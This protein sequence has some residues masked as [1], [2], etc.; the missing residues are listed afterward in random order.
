[1][2]QIYVLASAAFCLSV[3]KTSSQGIYQ[4]WGTTLSGGNENQGTIY[5]TRMDGGGHKPRPALPIAT[6]GGE[7]FG[8][9][10]LVYNN[11]IYTVAGGGI[12]ESGIIM[13]YDPSNDT[14]E[15]LVDM[16]TIGAEMSRTNLVLYNNKMYGVS[17]DQ[18]T[19]SDGFIFEFD[20]A[21]NGLIRKY[22]FSGTDYDAPHGGL[23]LWG[24]ELWGC[25]TAGTIATA[26][27]IYSYDLGSGVFTER[28]NFGTFLGTNPD[29]I[30][31][32][33]N[34]KIYGITKGGG[35][36][37]LGVLFEYNPGTDAYAV[38]H[39][40]SGG[41][42][43]SV[44]EGELTLYNNK[45]Y[46]QT[47]DEGA[48]DYG[49][50]FEFDPAIN[51]F[52]TKQQ[53]TA[54]N[55]GN[56]SDGFTLYNTK[57]Y[58]INPTGGTNNDGTVIEYDP[59]G[60]TVTKKADCTPEKGIR[61]NYQMTLYNGKMYGLADG[62]SPNGSGLAGVFFEYNP[63]PNSMMAKITFRQ[64]EGISPLGSVAYYNGKAF[65]LTS[66]GG[67][68]GEGVIWE[69]DL[70]TYTYTVRHHFDGSPD[71]NQGMTLYNG[72]LYGCTRLGGTFDDGVLYSFNPTNYTY[73][74][75]HS[76]NGPVDGGSPFGNPVVYN[77]KL[78]GTSPYSI[79]W[80]TIWEYALGSNT[81]T[82][83]VQ[84]DEIAHGKYPIAGLT[85]LNG[86]LW[87][88]CHNGGVND[89]GTI[90]EY[91]PAINGIIKRYDF[92]PTAA[93]GFNPE[94]GLTAV[95]NKLYG[96]TTFGQQ[97]YEFDPASGIYTVKADLLDVGGYFCKSKLA[98][99]DKTG[100]FYGT[101][102]FAGAL[103][104]G[105]LFE[106]DL[107][108][109]LLDQK[110]QFAPPI[111]T[112]PNFGALEK[113][114]AFAAPGNPGNCTAGGSAI[115]DPTNI[116]EWITF[117]NS[118]GDAV[119]EINPNGNN[120]GRVN[121]I[122]YVHDGPTRVKNGFY[123]LDRNITITTDNPPV[124]PVSVRLYTRK[125]EFDKLK[126]TPGSGIVSIGNLSVF[127]NNDNC[128]N[129]MTA[130]AQELPTFVT[131][132]GGDHVFITSVNSFSTFY[133]ASSL[134]VLPVHI[135]SL[136]GTKESTANKLSWVASCTTD[137][138]FVIERSTDGT[139]FTTVGTVNAQGQDC[140]S[141]FSFKDL[142]PPAKGW[143]RL[144]M[145]EMN[146]PV[147]YSNIIL[148]NRQRSE[149][150]TVSIF[151]NPVVDGT[152]NLQISAVKKMS[153]PL[154]ISDATGRV[155]MR[156][157]VTVQEGT[158]SFP[159]PVS[160]LGTGIYQLTYSDGEKNRVIRFIK[161]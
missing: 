144:R 34:N 140:N 105:N 8:R 96:T 29:C 126:N 26:G 61:A 77:N 86:S 82:K 21:T 18:V 152:V 161:Q 37:S 134:A 67:N 157:T 9:K 108:N 68:N 92:G 122:F 98:W 13:A 54:T 33:Y 146:G 103:S 83:K 80:G 159:L 36:N 47:T 154:T 155:V 19:G 149:E 113:I 60:N 123:Y 112:K 53:N 43:G 87:G 89:G 102:Y 5:T 70:A 4:Y 121:V 133:F 143:Y 50:I 135:L 64:N 78:Y 14:Y 62:G 23:L 137:V 73:T 95:N 7:G 17:Y 32:L 153:V 49:T 104:A 38:R 115:V 141:P 1:M 88:V 93:T 156:K 63:V 66:S 106:Y 75:L 158:N 132:W 90:Y 124:T 147:K 35:A 42:D 6:P 99:N 160:Q 81:F 57:L 142:N 72:I 84:F 101:T 20:P 65:G 116:N 46:G 12:H 31:S 127:K 109:D 79:S 71:F 28:A 74:V 48:N 138:E 119:A 69:Y 15:K 148:L 44:P 129:T 125:T 130:S 117:T 151:P 22:N 56:N 40:F 76:F 120:L 111:G 39:V 139:N 145:T 118:N 55:G 52:A 94:G 100:K 30:L 51:N 11:K 131:T 114:P 136:N 97:L 3:L 27:G 85:E 24:D 16:F 25:A 58:S 45:F 107:A 150:F 59:V 2:K 10:G 128:S 110:L 91:F 41:N